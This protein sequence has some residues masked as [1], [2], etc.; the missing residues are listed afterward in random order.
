MPAEGHRG[1]EERQWP[2]AERDSHRPDGS[3]SGWELNLR[4]EEVRGLLCEEW[5]G[6]PPSSVSRGT[7]AQ[8]SQPQRSSQPESGLLTKPKPGEGGLTVLHS[9]PRRKANRFSS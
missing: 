1:Q 8:R 4:W 2:A 6:Q 5:L 9:A 7:L 3:L